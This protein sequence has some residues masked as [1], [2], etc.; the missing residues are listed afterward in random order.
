[1]GRY[2]DAFDDI[3]A[4]FDT[5]AWKAESIKTFPNNF[6][7]TVG[8][9]EY[10]RVTVLTGG[11]SLNEKSISG[12]TIIEIFIPAGNGPYRAVQIADKLDS[13]LVGKN[14]MTDGKSTQFLFSSLTPK[15]NDT[16]N[17]SLYCMI[18]SIPFNHTG[19]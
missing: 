12:Q 4:V 17:P 1:M 10:I 2:Q 18:Y 8:S 16:V 14:F 5:V 6:T 9:N 3:F 15:G 19:V 7:G 11:P 13:Y